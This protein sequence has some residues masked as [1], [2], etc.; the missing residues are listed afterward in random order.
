M[1]LAFKSLFAAL[2]IGLV[3]LYFSLVPAFGSFIHPLTIMSV[4][5][6]G[7]IGAVWALLATNKHSAMPAF[8]G[9][10]L[11]SGIVVKNSI[12]LIDFILEE[13]QR[14]ASLEQ[15]IMGS[16]RT[17]TRPIIMT[18]VGTAAGMVPI[19]MQ[20]G[21]GLERLS[22]LAVVTIGGLF[23]STV[24]TLIYV[25]IF[26]TLFEEVKSLGIRRQNDVDYKG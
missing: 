14:G 5:P 8:I 7:L 25:P 10:I 18:A 19:A 17:R 4:I 16:I 26:Y 1:N 2:A 22:P 12:L 15:A 20:W 3:L 11:L 9:L 13:R 23:V 6:F 21:V 24:L